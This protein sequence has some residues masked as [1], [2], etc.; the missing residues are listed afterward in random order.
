[1]R[2]RAS[3]LSDYRSSHGVFSF[4]GS[5]VWQF[6]CTSSTPFYDLLQPLNE[7]V[8]V[9]RKVSM[10]ELS[11]SLTTGDTGNK[12]TF[13]ALSGDSLLD[14][15]GGTLYNFK[16]NGSVIGLGVSLEESKEHE[17]LLLSLGVQVYVYVDARVMSY[18]SM[19]SYIEEVINPFNNFIYVFD[20]TLS[21]SNQVHLKE[22][23]D[24][25]G[26]SNIRLIGDKVVK[27][28]ID[29]YSD[30]FNSVIGKYS[31]DLD[32]DGNVHPVTQVY[33]VSE[34][35]EFKPI[36]ELDYSKYIVVQE[37]SVVSK[38]S[39]KSSGSGSRVKSEGV[40]KPSKAGSVS[41]S[42]SSKG[43][44]KSSKKRKS[45]KSSKLDR[46]SLF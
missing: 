10:F 42:S 40:S 9:K 28:G 4:S 19:L 14:G 17:E 46:R 41:K 34:N 44:V 29:K 12:D 25:H 18:T 35:I 21:Y 6:V 45:V 31:L 22:F 5:P 20:I 8:V 39:G 15:R 13:R 16:A 43:S 11:Y 36:S 7:E 3:S 27:L 38:R 37:R 33:L 32:Y 24:S 23:L 30:M 2:L 1:M 26:Y